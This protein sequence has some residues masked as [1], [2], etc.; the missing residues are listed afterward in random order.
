MAELLGDLEQKIMKVIW[1]SDTPLKPSEVLERLDE[2][3]AY[4]TVM[5]VLKRLNDKG[6]LKRVKKGKA[7]LYQSSEKK[8]N[9]AKSRLKKLFASVLG[10]YNELAITQFVD[11]LEDNPEDIQKLKKYLNEIE[12]RN[13]AKN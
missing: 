11:S 4:T 12:Q 3:Y 8:E 9:F 1:E 5:T 10:T 6:L 13:T 2:G 7:Y